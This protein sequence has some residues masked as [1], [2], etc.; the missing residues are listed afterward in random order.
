MTAD[1]LAIYKRSGFVSI[2][3]KRRHSFA[4]GYYHIY[5]SD[6][7]V[8]ITTDSILHALHRSYDAILRGARSF[9][10]HHDGGRDIALLP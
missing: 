2:D 3:Q 1:E 6:L 10:V 5:A 8:L 7:P 4:S 9:G